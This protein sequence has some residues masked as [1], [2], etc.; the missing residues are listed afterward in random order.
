MKLPRISIITPSFNQ[1]KFI[2][3]NILSVM[4]QNYSNFEHIIIDGGSTNDTLGIL[5][6]YKH[7]IWI[8]EKDKGQSDAFNKGLKMASGD[9]IGW[10]N[11]DDVYLPNIF[12]F[13]ADK[14]TE[15]PE[16]DVI[17]G[18][19]LYIDENGRTIRKYY[20]RYF[21]ERRLLTCCYC[22]IPPMAAFFRKTI[23]NTMNMPLDLKYNYS[24]DHDLFL[25]IS[26]S[27][28]KLM[29][30]NSFLAS[31]RK[32]S[33][34]KTTFGIKEMRRES[35]DISRKYGK[36]INVLLLVNYYVI[37]KV[38]LTSPFIARYLRKIRYW[39]SLKR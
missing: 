27:G 39:L 13:V 11:S 29:Y 20:S 2:E 30:I 12:N 36:N 25:R 7:I 4:N 31:F 10:L 26:L 6:K 1:G 37:T 14:L 17:Y 8:S 21:S 16:V 9:I 15:N 33:E 24:M 18:N 32:H 19:C 3:T 35:F 5:K 34:S 28:F 22:Y 23:F 38:Y